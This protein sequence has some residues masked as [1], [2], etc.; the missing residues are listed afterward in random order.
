MHHFHDI[1]DCPDITVKKG[2]WLTLRYSYL[3]HG[4]E[5]KR[6]ACEMM[7]LQMHLKDYSKMR[8]KA[9]QMAHAREF[10]QGAPPRPS[11]IWANIT[12]GAQSLYALV[13]GFAL[14]DCHEPFQSF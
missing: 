6:V 2:E 10:L 9:L 7:P 14:E 5:R 8:E 3:W 11:N 12:Y 13:G 4:M 1:I